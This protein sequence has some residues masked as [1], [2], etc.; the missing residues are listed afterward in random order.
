[1]KEVVF[2]CPTSGFFLFYQEEKNNSIINVTV[3]QCP[4]SGFFLFYGRNGGKK[5][6]K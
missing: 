1:M 6:A 5:Y 3:F 2:Q 4:T